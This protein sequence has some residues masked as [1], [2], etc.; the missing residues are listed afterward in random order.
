MGPAR[1]QIAPVV[2]PETA[3]EPPEVPE[4]VLVITGTRTPRRVTDDPVGTERIGARELAAR[5]VRD[6]S[7]ALEAE[8][9]IQVERSFRGSSF[10]LRGLDAKYTRVLVDGQ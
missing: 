2:E 9:G 8:P 7:H 3:V 4:Q 1:A 6:A 5:N 10:Q